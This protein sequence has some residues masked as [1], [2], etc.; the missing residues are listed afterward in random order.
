MHTTTPGT[1]LVKEGKWYA[2]NLVVSALSELT[3]SV[4][5]LDPTSSA[6][7]QIK[8]KLPSEDFEELPDP[9]EISYHN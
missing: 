8:L 7:V 1:I 4:R 6:N 9:C 5:P 3:F 2:S